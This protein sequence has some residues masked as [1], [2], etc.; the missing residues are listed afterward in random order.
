MVNLKEDIEKVIQSGESEKDVKPSINLLKIGGYVS[1][2][3]SI[4]DVVQSQFTGKPLL[5]FINPDI[6]DIVAYATDT[7]IFFCGIGSIIKANYYQKV[8]SIAENLR[9]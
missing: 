2:V 1:I 8:Y 5:N 3:G 7:L 4:A 6:P 9:N